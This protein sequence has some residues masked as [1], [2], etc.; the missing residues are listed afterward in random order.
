MIIWAQSY[1]EKFWYKIIPSVVKGIFAPMMILI[2]TILIGLS[3]FGPIGTLLGEL[4]VQ[5]ISLLTNSVPWLAPTL[6]GGFGLFVVMTGA[7]YSLFPVVTQMTAVEGYDSFFN[8]G[9]LAA[10]LAIAGATCAVIFKTK[11]AGY[12]QYAISAT[13][14][15]SL[16]VSQP[17]LYGVAIPYK[18]VLIASVIG[19]LAGGFYAGITNFYAYGFVNPG[20]AA[21]PAYLSPDGTYG[22]LINGLITI[23]ISFGV[24]FLLV[25]LRPFEDMSDEEVGKLVTESAD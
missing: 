19:G 15:A 1:I 16:G 3:I 2:S 6:L 23:A 11:H 14:T 9:T 7:H 10:N 24:S 12:R 4:L 25:F 18:Q 8:P 21:L 13:F 22:N 20:L 17:A 5:F